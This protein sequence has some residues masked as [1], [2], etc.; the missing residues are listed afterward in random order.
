MLFQGGI[1]DSLQRHKNR[2]MRYVMALVLCACAPPESYYADPDKIGTAAPCTDEHTIEVFFS[3]PPDSTALEKSLTE[4]ISR[5]LEGRMYLCF[6]EISSE[7]V[8][9]AIEDAAARGVEI[10][11]AGDPDNAGDEGYRRIAALTKAENYVLSGD[12]LGEAI[13]HNKFA[14]LDNKEDGKCVWCGS[15]NATESDLRYNNNSVLIIRSEKVYSLYLKQLR[16]L[17]NNRTAAASEYPPVDSVEYVELDG[18]L[19][20]IFFARF[21]DKRTPEKKPMSNLVTLANGAVQEII[22]MIFTFGTQDDPINDL[23]G[24]V[25]EK[26]EFVSLRG[27]FDESQIGNPV[28]AR[29]YE[30]MRDSG[31]DVRYDGNHHESPES[32]LAG[33]RLHHKILIVDADDPQRAAVVCGSM[34]FTRSANTV[35]AENT[36]IVHSYKIAQLYKAE[37]ERQWSLAAAE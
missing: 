8:L 16:Y 24:A 34:N 32:P 10:Y 33:G 1:R 20:E 5:Q 37:F 36:I 19:L 29:V 11:F 26:S 21:G 3:E 14:L 13:M 27:V 30:T 23:A 6:Y 22:F 7:E 2:V 28:C 15:A 31:L 18:A 25:M 35:H 12:Y 9:C 4:L 17:M